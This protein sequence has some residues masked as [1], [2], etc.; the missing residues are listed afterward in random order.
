MPTRIGSRC[1]CRRV[2]CPQQMART[3][4]KSQMSTATVL[5]F[6]DG[7]SP[8]A[9]FHRSGEHALCDPQGDPSHLTAAEPGRLPSWRAQFASAANDL[10]ARDPRPGRHGGAGI[11]RRHSGNGHG[12]RSDTNIRCESRQM[13]YHRRTFSGAPGPAGLTASAIQARAGRRQLALASRLQ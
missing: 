11:P 8:V 2:S 9:R 1:G 3:C 6:D 4:Q 5:Q 13:P 10:G 12:R 7:I